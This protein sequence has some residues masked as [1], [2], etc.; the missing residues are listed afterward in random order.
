AEA[1]QHRLRSALRAVEDDLRENSLGNTERSNQLRA[2]K[3]ENQMLVERGWEAEERIKSLREEK[4]ILQSGIETLQR[5]IRLV[6]E[7]SKEQE[8]QLQQ[9]RSE[10]EQVKTVNLDLRERV[11]QM[12]EEMSLQDLGGLNNSLHSEIQQIESSPGLEALAE[13][14]SFRSNSSSPDHFY[15][16]SEELRSLREAHRQHEA[17]QKGREEQ[18]QRLNEQ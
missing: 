16:R 2:L 7:H 17:S 9:L 1:E 11:H 8:S 3:A 14:V 18:I 10:T 15:S 6:Q 4:G 13:S 5:S 12:K